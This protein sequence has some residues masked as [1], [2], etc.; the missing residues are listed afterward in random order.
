VTGPDESAGSRLRVGAVVSGTLVPAWIAGLLDA[1]ASSATLELVDVVV[2]GPGGGGGHAAG[3]APGWA[4]ALARCDERL[5]GRRAEL[6][7]PVDLR[8][9]A[10]AGRPDIVL[11]LTG[12][13][14]DADDFADADPEIWLLKGVPVR[15]RSRDAGPPETAA[16]LLRGAQVA[17]FE[18]RM[19]VAGPGGSRVLHTAVCPRHPTSPLMTDEYLAAS[20]WQLVVERLR[21]A[22]RTRGGSGGDVVESEGTAESQRA[23]AR[24]EAEASPAPGA[25]G[26]APA[27]PSRVAGLRPGPGAVAAF[28]W[29]TAGRQARKA[30]FE[31]QWHLLVGAVEADRLLPDPASL[32]PVTPEPGRYWADPFVVVHEGRT[33]LFFEEFIYASRRGRIATVTLDEWGRPGAERVALEL[34]SH[35]SYPCVFSHEGRTYMVPESAGTSSLDLYECLEMPAR[36]EHRRTLL[37]GVRLVDASVFRWNDLWWMFASLKKPAGLRTA[38]LLVLYMS[39]DLV[40][41]VWRPH[42]ASPLL[43]DVTNARP[44]GAP[45]A[46]G[47][48]LFRPAQDGSV[49]YGWAITMNEV[50]TL[51]PGLYAERRLGTLRPD[52]AKGLA[53]T[54]TI[55]RAGGV[56]VMDACRYVVRDPRRP[57]AESMME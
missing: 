24:P 26:V 27:T 10:G 37:S 32:Q 15:P 56:V 50:V 17:T 38:E 44:A 9:R 3:P 42:P 45:F 52:W 36:W 19:R 54:H 12:R 22:A 35:L 48:R 49:D 7:A 11:D 40:S 4:R 28:A 46:V 20:A 47:D 16:D 2:T 14:E 23:G 5:F 6:L 34:G 43:A 1:V 13:D 51:T 30:I 21:A 29:R 33:H 57:R 41:G 18:L 39:E 25:Q 55:N 8:P 53:G 31:K